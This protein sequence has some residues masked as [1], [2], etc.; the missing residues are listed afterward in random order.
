MVPEKVITRYNEFRK[1]IIYHLSKLNERQFSWS[2][3]PLRPSQYTPDFF[4][5]SLLKLPYTSAETSIYS[6][7]LI[8]SCRK[9]LLVTQSFWALS[10]NRWDE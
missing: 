10:L 2:E 3:Q 9:Y 8:C 4:Y 5:K 6:S 7:T 1:I